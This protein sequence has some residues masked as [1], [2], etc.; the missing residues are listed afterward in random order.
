MHTFVFEIGPEA[1][2]YVS[3]YDFITFALVRVVS[4]LF[5]GGED[6]KAEDEVSTEVVQKIFLFIEQN[7]KMEENPNGGFSALL[8]V[9]ENSFE[10]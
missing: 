10:N 1:K 7:L 2:E 5:F 9:P 8:E 4:V 6:C 3:R